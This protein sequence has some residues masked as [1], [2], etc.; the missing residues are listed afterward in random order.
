MESTQPPFK[1]A[2]ER[3]AEFFDS[4]QPRRPFQDSEIDQISILL[5][6]SGHLAHT[7]PR[8]YIV[9]RSIGQLDLLENLLNA[10]FSDQEFPV[11]A[12]GLPSFLAPRIR[13]AI[14]EEQYLVLTKSLDLENGRHRHYAPQEA[15]PFEI[16]GRLGSGG[17]GQVDRISSRTSFRQYALKRIRRRAVFGNNSK[18]A[19]KGFLN[20]MKIVKSLEHRHII[21]YIGSYTDKNYL[22]LVMSPVAEA[23]LAVY[24]QRI[25]ESTRDASIDAAVL[26]SVSNQAT[27]AEL[28]SNLRR[29]FGCLASALTYL[30]DRSVRHKDIKPQNILVTKDNI[31]FSDFGLSRDFLDD[32]GS[33]TSG[34]TPASPRYC[35]P[36]VATYAA[37][38]TSSDIWSLGCVYFEMVAAL[39][40]LSVDWIKDYYQT[41][42]SKATHFHANP[43]ATESLLYEWDA[44][45]QKQDL[46][47]LTWIRKMTLTDRQARPLAAQVLDMIVSNNDL[48]FSPGTFC[49]ICCLHGEE[50]D[51]SDSLADD[52][53]LIE[54]PTIT[55]QRQRRQ[56]EENREPKQ[57]KNGTTVLASR[58][59]LHIL[60]NQDVPSKKVISDGIVPVDRIFSR[61]P[62]PV[63]KPL[64]STTSVGKPRTSFINPAAQSSSNTL[65]SKSGPSTI[66]LSGVTG[67]YLS[68]YA[69]ERREI[70][71]EDS[72]L[73]LN[74]AVTSEAG[75]KA[76]E[77]VDIAPWDNYNEG[78][79][80]MY[81]VPRTASVEAC[82]K[83]IGEDMGIAPD[84]IR[85]WIIVKR[86]NG[87]VRPDTVLSTYH[88]SMN[89]V[90]M[91]HGRKGRDLRLWIEL[92]EKRDELG[93]PL[94]GYK[95]VNLKNDNNPHT[96]M[97]FLKS[98]DM[99]TQ[100]L[101]GI[102][103]FYAASQGIVSDF[104]PR[105]L[106]MLGWQPGIDI[107]LFE[108]IKPTLIEPIKPTVTLTRAALQDGDIIVLQRP[109]SSGEASDITASGGFVEIEK[110]YHDL[111]DQI[112]VEFAPRVRQAPPLPQFSS[113]W[114]KK[115]KYD[116][117]VA[118]VAK[119]LDIEPMRLK[120]ITVDNDG[121]PG[122]PI[123]LNYTSTLKQIL[124]VRPVSSF[125]VQ[126]SLQL[127]YD[128][129]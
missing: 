20:E 116:L 73:Y 24:M 28:R 65:R 40:G 43:Q 35:A 39:H 68:R 34:L 107:R 87:T 96:I 113:L 56:Y 103:T 62:L 66:N 100:R 5:E 119:E 60:P 50:G 47:P 125:D 23:D 104:V 38:N 111:D 81:K 1:T 31:L 76:Y 26:S 16:L 53:A 42:F 9:L 114:R 64:P 102:G 82:V 75:F 59:T 70:E 108:E 45:W 90:V 117:F 14:V 33:T 95:L 89:D 98:F 129:T 41:N 29:Y 109:V 84:M 122:Q 48:D 52:S 57:D 3:L 46:M 44:T 126:R 71:T 72:H 124:P 77:G 97:L 115:M 120:F 121:K 80:T 10:G 58:R 49:G 85:P 101:R 128:I 63:S 25:C 55:P 110:F 13:T 88:M 15:L 51:S 36:E 91:R 105:A 11:E 37:R 6:R 61:S 54:E 2:A 17:Q 79:I 30:H 93:E 78:K 22:G 12:R 112:T 83:T 18:E 86:Q 7:C 4:S 94:F 8:T 106:K 127:Y 99:R 27:A 32:A 74:V 69:F 92:A 19:L 21:R 118:T 123:Q 67:S